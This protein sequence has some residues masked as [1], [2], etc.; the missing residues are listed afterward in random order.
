MN[1]MPTITEFKEY[2]SLDF[3][4]NADPSL[5]V[6]DSSISKAFGE[7]NFG[8]NQDLFSSQERYTIG[9]L[10]LAAHYLVT[11]LRNASQGLKGQYNW[12]E[13]SKSVGSVSQGFSIPQDIMNNP[14][15]MMYTRTT[16]GGKYLEL[17]LPGLYGN[18]GVAY[19]RT[20]P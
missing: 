2:F 15:F 6:T 4:Y 12:A 3:P 16:Y 9:F 19:G 18:V 14:M 17:L 10:Y 13:T 8:I 5:G 1:L 7:A 20:L 11:D